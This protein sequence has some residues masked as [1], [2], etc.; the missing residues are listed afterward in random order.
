MTCLPA[1]ILTGA[2]QGGTPSRTDDHTLESRHLVLVGA[3]VVLGLALQAHKLSADAAAL[4]CLVVSIGLVTAVGRR[5]DGMRRA[6]VGA[7][8]LLVVLI[9]LQVVLG[10][11]SATDVLRGQGGGT[12][13]LAG[14]AT[15]LTWVGA[16]GL[17]V[18]ARNVRGH[19]LA[20]A[21]LL[22]GVLLGAMAW[23]R[24]PVTMDV[25]LYQE[26]G[27]ERVLQGRN[28]YA[29]GLENPYTE[30]E[31]DR[32]FAPELVEEGRFTFGL[33]YPPTSLAF[34][35]PG[36]LAGDVRLAHLFAVLVSGTA[37]LFMGG[38]PFTRPARTAAA[39]FLSSPMLVF[40]VQQSWTETFVIALLL[41]AVWLV[42]HPA[43]TPFWLGLGLLISVKQY[44]ILLAAALVYA[45]PWSAGAVERSRTLGRGVAVA[46][47]TVLPFVVWA[48]LDVWRS[49]VTVH[50][51]QPY[52]TDS[53]SILAF[54]D[55]RLGTDLAPLATPLTLLSLGLAAW[56]VASMRLRTWTGVGIAAAVSMAGFLL[57][58][59]QAHTNY[60]LVVV[61]AICLA[62]S[63]ATDR[64]AQ[65]DV[66]VVDDH[67]GRRVS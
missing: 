54:A 29:P 34:A 41:V 32:F 65:E 9:T 43:S 63:L 12:V 61:A 23:L 10:A 52:R 20:A 21:A 30:E 59:K 7:T 38:L 19:Q 44:A 57:F 36:H 31:T 42:R 17:A 14:V 27:A 8:P 16:V 40:V 39:V 62:L 18:P 4:T 5:H 55:N 66:D 47:A 25:L 13:L 35:L 56:Y 22:L 58:A 26:T 28:P 15:G 3:A 6:V 48:P 24:A 49:L 2:A 11:L 53:L 64:D 46:L 45:R 60:W 33:P 1:P 51:L 67:P 37:L 50:L